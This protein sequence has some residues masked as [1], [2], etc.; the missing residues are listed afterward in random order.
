MCRS[1]VGGRGQGR[2]WRQRRED[3]MREERLSGMEAVR[4]GQET[5]LG[6]YRV[7]E[8]I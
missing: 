1:E 3:E 6:K 7:W 5:P 4:P 8:G 2:C